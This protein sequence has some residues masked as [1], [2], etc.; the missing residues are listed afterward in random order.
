MKSIKHFLF[1]IFRQSY[2]HLPLLLLIYPVKQQKKTTIRWMS[3]IKP[4]Q[5][6]QKYY[7]IIPAQKWILRNLYFLFLWNAELPFQKF[8]KIWALIWLHA[9]VCLENVQQ[10]SHTL[11][12]QSLNG[13][14]VFEI[15][16][17]LQNFT[18]QSNLC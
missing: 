4:T 6:S 15:L 1:I 2:L 14:I 7:W 13:F 10:Y 3:L 11:K 12:I 16:C 18:V 5:Q 17:L 8:E 9:I